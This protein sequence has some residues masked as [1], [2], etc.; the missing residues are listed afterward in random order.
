MKVKVCS[1]DCDEELEEIIQRTLDEME[2]A[3][4]YLVQINYS[5]TICYNSIHGGAI[6]D[7]SVVMLLDKEK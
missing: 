7:K 3:K 2:K 5:N 1:A 6:S 4:F